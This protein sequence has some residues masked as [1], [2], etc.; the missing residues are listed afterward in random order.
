MKINVYDT[1]TAAAQAAAEAAAGILREAIQA[2]GH[3]VFVAATGNSQLEFLKHLTAAP[4][5]SWKHTTLFHLDEYIGIPSSHPASFRRYLR[6]RLTSLVPV[7]N[8]HFVQGDA[9]DLTAELERLNAAIAATAVD[10]AFIG[11]G[12]NGHIAFNDPPADFAT[13]TPFIVVDLDDACRRQQVGEGWFDSIEAV[14]R[15]AVSMSVKQIMTSARILCTVLDKRKAHA[16]KACLA[17]EIGPMFPASILR[18]HPG[19][20]LFLDRDAAGLLSP[21]ERSA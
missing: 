16:V 6:E 4:G 5:I 11:I 2:K 15:Q 9:P 21:A 1:P 13:E 19:C 20:D 17:G 3:A 12:E 10:V 14:P 8:V 7:G 18:T